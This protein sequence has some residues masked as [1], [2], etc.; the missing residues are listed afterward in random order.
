MNDAT[1]LQ[2]PRIGESVPLFEARSTMG[3]LA[4]ADYLGKWVI[5]FSHPADFTPVC[6]SEFVALARASGEFGK[7]DCA[8]I[9]LSVDSLY[10]HLAWIRMIKDMSGVEVDFPIVED[11][12]MVIAN[13]YGMLSP[14][15][16]DAGT[17]RSTFF[18]DPAGVLRAT[19]CYPANV[20]RS[21]PEMLR[22]LDALQRVEGSEVLA[23]ADWMPGDD[24]LSAPS[25]TVADALKPKEASG[26]F[27]QPVKDRK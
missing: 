1:T 22:L 10:S 18:V 25:E 5:L 4:L 13:A 19:T 11:P 21:I 8:L 26:W 17:V 12:S 3:P 24:L 6:T 14:E 7:R 20:G 27:F 16:Q 23:P 9:G 2:P 15:A